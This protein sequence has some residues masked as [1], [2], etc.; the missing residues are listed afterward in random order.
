MGSIRGSEGFSYYIQ[1]WI[2]CKKLSNKK[3]LTPDITFSVTSDS[4]HG[5]IQAK[6]PE[7]DIYLLQLATTDGSDS[8]CYLQSVGKLYSEKAV[9]KHEYGLE[10]VD[11]AIRICEAF[12]Y[13]HQSLVDGSKLPV[14]KCPTTQFSNGIDFPTG[15]VDGRIAMAVTKGR[16]LY[17]GHGFMP[18]MPPLYS[19]GSFT[20]AAEYAMEAKS[21]DAACS[22]WPAQCKELDAGSCYKKLFQEGNCITIAAFYKDCLERNL[23]ELESQLTNDR[24]PGGCNF[25]NVVDTAEY[26][27]LS[28]LQKDLLQILMVRHYYRHSQ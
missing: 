4:A 28:Q 10:L 14:A 6:F 5:S 16:T 7:N 17:M 25:A 8:D 24:C 15:F 22:K 12:G 1:R 20:G 3:N 13:K 18:K 21:T 26:K 27:G 23:F 19:T 2:C 11:L 9:T